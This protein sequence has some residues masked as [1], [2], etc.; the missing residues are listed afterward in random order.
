MAAGCKPVTKKHREFESHP[1][2]Y[3]PI[4]G[5]LIIKGRKRMISITKKQRDY[6][7]ANGC[8]FGEDLHRTYGKKKSYYAT[9][10]KK[11][12]S[13]LRQYENEVICH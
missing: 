4:M 13:L 9:E 12:K 6:L 5:N 10:N 2:N 3:Y 11:V 8:I 1:A 7:E